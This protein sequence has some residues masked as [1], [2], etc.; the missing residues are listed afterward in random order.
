MTKKKSKRPGSTRTNPQAKFSKKQI[1]AIV[2]QV[3]SGELSRTQ[4]CQQYGMAYGTVLDWM[5]RYASS[6]AAPKRVQLSPQQQRQVARAVV[7]GS[8]TIHEAQVAYSIACSATLRRWVR[9]Y[10]QQNSELTALHQSSPQ[11]PASPDTTTTSHEQDKALQ[12]ARLQIAALETLIDIAEQ[13]YHIS[14]RKKAGAKQ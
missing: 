12:Q 3:A 4:A 10:K 7:E 6:S 9:V 8:M 2:E 1:H 11:M 5:K 14:I 13:H